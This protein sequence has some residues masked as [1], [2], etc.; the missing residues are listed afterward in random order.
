MKKAIEKKIDEVKSLSEKFKKARSIIAYDYQG[1]TVSDLTNLRKDLHK[2][3]CEI[4]ILKNN[5]SKRASEE[6]GY[7][8]LAK[9]LVGPKALAI[10][11]ED[12][13]IAA[14]TLSEFSKQ[15]DKIK[16]TAGVVAGQVINKEMITK[17]ANIPPRDQL[18]TMLAVGLISPIRNIT[19]GLNML[20]EKQEKENK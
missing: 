16:L 11:Y 9:E 7:K 6:L 13:I 19:I 2:E 3:N 17:L 18:L 15:N 14:K 5:I 10:S 8:D 1:L 4:S 20:K 12:E